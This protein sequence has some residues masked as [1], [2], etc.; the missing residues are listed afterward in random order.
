VL[1]KINPK[2]IIPEEHVRNNRKEKP[3]GFRPEVLKT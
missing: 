3:P 1:L 2:S